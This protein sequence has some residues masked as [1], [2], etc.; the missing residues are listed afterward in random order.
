MS[1]HNREKRQIFLDRHLI[2]EAPKVWA[3]IDKQLKIQPFGRDNIY[4]QR[5]ENIMNLSG[6]A[7]SAIELF[8]KFIVGNGFEDEDFGKFEVNFKK[9]TI[10]KLLRKLSKDY[11]VW[12]GFAIHVNF[13]AN[14][15]ISSLQYI[16]FEYCRKGTQDDH[17]FVNNIAVYDDWS[18]YK[19]KHLMRKFITYIDVFN[20]DPEV[21]RA[22]IELAGSIKDYNGQLLYFSDEDTNY[23]LC[24]FDAVIKDVETDGEVSSFKNSNVKTNFLASH[25]FEYPGKFATT[26]EKD[27]F[28]ADLEVYQGAKNA[29][30]IMLIENEHLQQG[31]GLKIHKTDIQNGDSL[32]QNTEESV[33]KSIRMRYAQPAVLHGDLIPGKLG[34]GKEVQDAFRFYNQ[35]TN[36]D[37]TIFE[38]VFEM[39]MESYQDSTFTNFEISPLIFGDEEDK[40]TDED[41]INQENNG[42][43]NS[44]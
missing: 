44:D 39:I 43:P 19:R 32:F 15:K 35:H 21:V 30:K 31:V 1:D 11:S 5:V 6:V 10:N 23:P 20:P 38:E 18:R 16:P 2:K 3:P 24:S 28:I 36:D 8:K 22:Q 29:S 7:L 27:E 41:L 14:L 4:P 12:K 33:K 40:T 37:R 34:G 26:N 42:T 9:E 13:N 17:E 25:I